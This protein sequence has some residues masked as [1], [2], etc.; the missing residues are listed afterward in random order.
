MTGDFFRFPHIPHL[1]WS[2]DGK[3]RDDKVLSSTE[4]QILL[5]HEVVVEEKLDGANLG[6][7]VGPDAKLRAQNRG[8]YLQ[9]P[10][11]GQ[12]ARVRSWLAQHEEALRPALG[13]QL[14][15]F[16]E[17]CAAKHSLDYDKLPDWWLLFDIY[18]RHEGRFWSTVRRNDFARQLNLTVVPQQ[19]YGRL[20]LAQ[21]EELLLTEGSRCRRGHM[22]GLVV[23]QE[24]KNWLTKR[25]K[26]VRQEFTQAIS[27][28]WRN[29]VIEWNILSTA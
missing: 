3:P 11:Q 29:R 7:S 20:N 9:A 17:W 1:A 14:I 24:G 16:G 21:L 28:H 8:A 26:L 22:E 15:A 10:Y 6:F 23:R 13:E 5:S 27:E 25:A 2:G 18:D 4:A 19:Q 12:F